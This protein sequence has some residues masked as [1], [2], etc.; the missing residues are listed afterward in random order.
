MEET[1]P[2]GCR[3]VLRICFRACLVLLVLFVLTLGF[4]AWRGSWAPAGP[5]NRLA[6]WPK[7][8]A[9]APASERAWP[10]YQQAADLLPPPPA[11]PDP[12]AGTLSATRTKS[13]ITGNRPT[14]EHAEQVDTY[15]ADPDTQAAMDLY[16]E[17]ARRPRFARDPGPADPGE[18]AFASHATSLDLGAFRDAT[19][20]FTTDAWLAAAEGNPDRALDNIDTLLGMARHLHAD[21]HTIS[22][23]VAS[24]QEAS[25]TETLL[26]ILH[27]YPRRFT[28]PRLDAAIDT[29]RAHIDARP[30]TFSTASERLMARER[31]DSIFTPCGAMTSRGLRL[32]FRTQSDTTRWHP[33]YDTA[34][35]PV[36]L[37]A[38]SREQA[39]AAIDTEYNALERYSELDPWNAWDS[40]EADEID[41]Y[42][43]KNPPTFA[44]RAIFNEGVLPALQRAV[45]AHWRT[46]ADLRARLAALEIR[47]L[48]RQLGRIP[49]PEQAAPFLPPDPFDG[50]P[51]RYAVTDAGW[52]L[53]SIGNDRDD[54]AGRHAADA[55]NMMSPERSAR[56]AREKPDDYDGD[57]VFWPPP[58]DD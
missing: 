45:E 34:L 24:A 41:T 48:E 38:P 9:D 44:H 42:T 33:L 28:Q 8:W 17:A 32:V 3:R 40:P 53:Y 18:P 19:R 58:A 52:T 55:G 7:P 46:N 50:Q 11:V 15:L 2:T 39:E 20:L 23:L 35:A 21:A 12:G 27:A 25:A 29:L 57:H 13:I 31:A 26:E 16:R 6:E 14:P 5:Q 10:L 30:H 4:F 51:L 36:A 49:T 56:F 22:V 47:R 54:D 43:A 1:Q 37:F